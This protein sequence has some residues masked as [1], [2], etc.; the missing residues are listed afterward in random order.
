MS[1][2]QADVGSVLDHLVDLGRLTD[3]QYLGHAVH[4]ALDWMVPNAD[5]HKTSNY[6]LL[7]DWQ[8]TKSVQ[9]VPRKTYFV[10]FSNCFNVGN[11]LD[12][13]I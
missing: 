5:P 10:Q 7:E 2:L 3:I 12:T 8:V 1:D 6:G 13:F 9:L 4:R 11:F